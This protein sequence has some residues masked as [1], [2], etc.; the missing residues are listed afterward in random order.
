MQIRLQVGGFQNE[1]AELIVVGM[2]EDQVGLSQ[3]AAA[4]DQ[5]LGG[6]LTQLIADGDFASKAK[7]LSLLYA[8]G[9]GAAKR[10]L[11][12][13]LGRTSKLS[14]ESIRVAA[15]LAAKRVLSLGVKSYT[16]EVFGA[17]CRKNKVRNILTVGVC[18]NF[19][20]VFKHVQ[21]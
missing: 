11:L 19:H 13:G 15:G 7:E 4:V 2:F 16:A 17:G 3:A 12:V 1:P 10:V 18:D 14:P 20:P 21:I 9:R 8:A 6:Q 5:A